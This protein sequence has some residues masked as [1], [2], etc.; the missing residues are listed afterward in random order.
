MRLVQ[1]PRIRES[2]F[3]E[4]TVAAGADSAGPYNGMILPYS[5]GDPEAEHDRLMAIVADQSIEPTFE[6]G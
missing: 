4:A 3:Y 5:Y 1:S 6:V 2:P